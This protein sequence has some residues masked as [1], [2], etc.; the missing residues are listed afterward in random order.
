MQY[1][2]ICNKLSVHCFSASATH[3]VNALSRSVRSVCVY[4]S[5]CLCKATPAQSTCWMSVSI[6]WF[7]LDYGIQLCENHTSL[8]TLN[9]V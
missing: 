6:L 9:E 2:K 5:Q 4:Y 7:A 3:T 1:K 8:F